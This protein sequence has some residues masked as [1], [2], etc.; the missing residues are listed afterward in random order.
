MRSDH[1]RWS[2]QSHRVDRQPRFGGRWCDPSPFVATS[3]GALAVLVELAVSPAA[4]RELAEATLDVPGWIA[5]RDLAGW[6]AEN[7]RRDAAVGYAL[8]VAIRRQVSAPPAGRLGPSVAALA[9][10]WAELRSDWELP[11]ALGL[12]LTTALEPSVAARKLELS[13]AFELR[14]R[15]WQALTGAAA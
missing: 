11:A 1:H 14:R 5:E 7:A 12:L 13:M 4:Q 10:A 2:D 6:L 3:G 8:E 9:A 15:A